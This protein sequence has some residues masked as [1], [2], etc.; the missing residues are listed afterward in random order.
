MTGMMLMIFID[1][2]HNY[3]MTG[4][5]LM[6]FIDIYYNYHTQCMTWYD[7]NDIHIG[8]K[9]HYISVELLL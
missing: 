4:M 1:I 7:S 8:L 5:M 9:D 3:H 2:Y 6:I